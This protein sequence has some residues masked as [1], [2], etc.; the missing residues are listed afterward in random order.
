[1]GEGRGEE[2]REEEH[3][4]ETGGNGPKFVLSVKAEANKFSPCGIIT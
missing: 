1:M 2:E 4:M 3:R